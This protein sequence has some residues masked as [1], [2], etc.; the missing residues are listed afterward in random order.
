MLMLFTSLNRAELLDYK[1]AFELTHYLKSD[2]DYIPWNA[3][4]GS[5]SFIDLML[6]D[7]PGYEQYEVSNL[8]SC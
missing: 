2:P 3:F 7:R 5:M 4:I 8:T 6:Q 1:L